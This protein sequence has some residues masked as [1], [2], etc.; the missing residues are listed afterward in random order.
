V[1]VVQSSAF[2]VVQMA[3]FESVLD[4][5]RVSASMLRGADEGG[6]EQRR[7][8]TGSGRFLTEKDIQLRA[9]IETSDIFKS[10]PGMYDG[11][12]MR[13]A[14]SAIG[15]G[16]PP[17]CIPSVFIDGRPMPAPSPDE[18]DSWVRPNQISSIEIYTDAP[19]PQFQVAL[20]GCGSIV[21]W[22]KR[23]GAIR[24]PPM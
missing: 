16:E 22:T 13:S 14:F 1:D 9:P 5:M 2:V 20:S 15:S 6:F 12:L 23:L 10:V 11:F 24:K 4:T 18:L 21:I 19:P 7:R 3:T 17:R 8:S